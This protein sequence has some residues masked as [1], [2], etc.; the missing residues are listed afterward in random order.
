MRKVPTCRARIAANERVAGAFGGPDLV[1]VA[2]EQAQAPKDS[3][4]ESQ[5]LMAGPNPSNAPENPWH[6]AAGPTVAGCEIHF[7]PPFRIPG[8]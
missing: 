8:F 2:L 4:P 5:K 7:A 1:Q 3:G 6:R